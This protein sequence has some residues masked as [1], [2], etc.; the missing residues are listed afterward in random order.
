MFREAEVEVFKLLEKV[1]GVKKKKTLPEIDKSSD[2]SGLFVV[3]VEIAVTLVR[4][5]SMASDKDDG[6]FR[7][8]LH[9]MDEVKPWLRELDSNSYE[10]F[11][12]VLV[13][14]LGK[15]ALNF[16]EKTSFSDKDLVITF[17]RKT[18]IEYAKSSIKDQLF[19]VAKRMCSVLF[20]SEEDRLS[21]I[22]DILDCVAR[23][24]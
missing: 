7:R 1:H 13:Y 18:L 22:M 9:L 19:K 5:A 14:N 2:D 11:H 23:E 16:L 4:C 15:C 3:F 21:Y 8:V 10:K 20:M 12:K 6:Y 17:C 24:I